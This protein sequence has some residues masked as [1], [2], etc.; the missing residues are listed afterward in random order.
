[1][2]DFIKVIIHQDRC[3]HAYSWKI[4]TKYW[5][6]KNFRSQQILLIS[7][8]NFS[9]GSSSSWNLWGW[10]EQ[11][12]SR[13]RNPIDPSLHWRRRTGLPRGLSSSTNRHTGQLVSCIWNP[14]SSPPLVYRSCQPNNTSLEKLHTF[15][16]EKL[17]SCFRNSLKIFI[18]NGK[19]PLEMI[20]TEWLLL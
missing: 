14:T 1:M 5:S 11:E 9:C 2:L 13:F 16:S 19:Q 17:H 20:M 12:V 7:S 8:S 10:P 4:C 15:S 6:S 18:M 3:K